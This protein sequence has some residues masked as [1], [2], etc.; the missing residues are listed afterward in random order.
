MKAI[1]ITPDNAQAIE[2]ALHD[3]NGR[4]TSHAYTKY[5]EIA[6]VADDAEKTLGELLFKKDFSG[7]VWR[8]TSGSV[9][10]NCYRGTR[11]GTAIAIERRSAAWFL[12]EIGQ[13][14]LFTNGGGRGHLTLTLLQ[15]AA[16]TAK[17][18]ARYSVAQQIALAA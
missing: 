10:A 5:A 4:S 8:E 7:A 18:R 17:L 3:V 12:V 13:V 9:V 2:S 11:N 1:K 16:A 14:P 15:D 6:A